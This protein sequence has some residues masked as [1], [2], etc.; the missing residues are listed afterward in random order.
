MKAQSYHYLIIGG[1]LAG[2]SAA[3]GIRELDSDSPILMLCAEDTLPYNRPPLSKTLWSGE[4]QL[5]SIFIHDA[6]YYERNGIHLALRT[7]AVT[8]NAQEKTV[9]DDRGNTYRYN[10]LLLATGSE[11]R[12]LSIEG[13]G[14][15]DVIHY[16]FLDDYLKLRALAE[17]GKRVTVIGGGFIGSELAAS[18]AMDNLNVSMIFPDQYLC[19]KVFPHQFGAALQRKY[20]QRGVQIFSS[21]R[22]VMLSKDADGFVLFT[23]EGKK[24][25]AD[26]VVAGVGVTP[27][28]HLAQEARLDVAQ[29]VMVNEYLQTSH[30]DIYAAGDNALFPSALFAKRMRHEHWDNAFHQGALAG[31]NMAGSREAY[32]Y[33]PAFFSRLFDMKYEAVGE[34]SSDM[35]TFSDWQ[36]ENEKGIIYYLSDGKL[37]GMMMCNIL[38]KTEEARNL[39]RKN[40][41]P[42]DAFAHTHP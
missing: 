28:I 3:D 26:V 34:I 19:S 4:S 23:N 40:L 2:A 17:K 12:H 30:P 29:G 15:E 8:V 41:V 33:I 22:P 24:I 35:K 10:K 39:I 18:L 25:S 31:R 5:D 1:G 42:Q 13:G 11:P 21:D 27:A 32:T 38:G 37:Q 14:R 16:R 7:R 20:V 6:A 36:Q 9:T